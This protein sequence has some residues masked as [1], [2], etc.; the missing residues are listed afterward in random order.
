MTPEGLSMQEKKTITQILAAEGIADYAED[1]RQL[2]A[3]ELRRRFAFASSGRVNATRVIKNL[4]WQAYTAIRDGQRPPIT[5]NLRSFWYT[6]VKPVLSRLGLPVEGRRATEL[7][8]DAFVEL[9][10]RHRLFHYR[11]FGFLDEG[12]H[13]RVVGRTN[14]ALLL[15]AEKD[16]RF[17]LVRGIAQEFDATGLALGGY[18]SSLATE[19]LLSALQQGILPEPGAPADQALHLFSVV[20]FDPSG[21]WI[22]REF[23]D[24]L[25]AFGVGK[26]TLHTLVRPERLAPEQV[27]LSRYTLKK[28]SETTNWLRAT[29]GIAD[30][31]YGLEA[32]AFTPAAIRAAF[33]EEA[34]PYL[35][36][37]APTAEFL[38][39]VEE[40]ARRRQAA[41][42]LVEV[43]ARL[44]QLPAGELAALARHLRARLA[45]EPEPTAPEVVE[46][47][48]Q[49]RA[50][51]LLE[52]ARRMR[53]QRGQ[54]A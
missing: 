7:V 4:I 53:E 14:G 32:D 51:E 27:R 23:A 2:S 38:A 26:V 13:A 28:G 1:L 42:P 25:R 50:E 46:G 3:A 22:E 18:P 52:L 37:P 12:A 15:F 11:D 8:Y 33:V 45:P 54:E 48:M 17:E 41:L 47:T 6:D 35:R 19:Y 43:A 9:V 10:T 31:P 44:A 21:Y 39:L 5:G 34:A 30:E 40:A 49:L 36:A 29:G 24:Q 20:D 16:G